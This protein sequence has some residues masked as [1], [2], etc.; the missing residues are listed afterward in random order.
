MKKIIL[1]F[2]LLTGFQLFAENQKSIINSEIKDVKV[3]LSGAQVN[4]SFKTTIEA[5]VTELAI[6]NLSSQI[7]RNSI[8]VSINGDAMI[9]ST[10][11]TLD[12]LKEKKVTPELKKLQ[13]SLETFTDI[14]NELNLLEAVYTE[15]T[16]M[17]NANKAVGGSNVGV[18]SD[19]LHKAID[20]YRQRMIEVKGK[21]LEIDKKKVKLAEKIKR[22]N[23]QINTENGK[24]NQP[25]GT[26]LV[27]VSS[28][29][30]ENVDVS[31]SYF[32]RGASWIPSYDLRAKDV[33]SPVNLLY[34]ASVSQNT[35]ENWENVHVFLSTGNPTLGGNKPTLS[36]WYINFI[37]PRYEQ[38]LN[39]PTMENMSKSMR[40]G[41][42]KIPSSDASSMTDNVQ[43]QENQVVTEF[44]IQL[45]YTVHND[46]KAVMMDIQSF[47]LPAAFSYFTTPKLDKDAFLM[48][49]ITGWEKLNLL[50]GA[51]NIYLENSYVGQSFINPSETS[52]TLQLSFGRDKRI[53]VK[54][55]KV[56]DMNT[57]KFIG[58][59][60]EK[61]FLFETTIRNSKKEGITITLD[62]QV[63]V[64]KD[65]N[66]KVTDVE[67]SG[68]NYNPDTGMINW[69]LDLKSGETKKI[70]FGYK[71]KY[72]KDKIIGGL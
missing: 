51:S 10:V 70:R 5:G 21:I 49:N 59:N 2:L 58:G 40:M 39:A 34:K 18:N 20:F 13:D 28:K 12:Y 29:Q 55:E 72:P 42:I 57:T 26:I 11:Y 22:M 25:F 47:T 62:D 69:K 53:T 16:G 30:K 68:G 44:D 1:F 23:E 56:K 17:L 27:N 66:I 3:F 4:R 60:I 46:G 41:E 35:G 6:E 33:N 71:V 8:T 15:E 54:R 31:L 61:E 38:I 7:D 24:M 65:S 50:P 52:D 36:P 32:A 19:N 64:S 48:A 43:M 63:P 45:P 37:T 14:M 67:L 9:I